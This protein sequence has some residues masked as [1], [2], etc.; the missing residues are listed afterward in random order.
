MSSLGEDVKNAYKPGVEEITRRSTARESAATEV[1]R[2]TSDVTQLRAPD[3]QRFALVSVGTAVLAPRVA[4]PGH[5]AMRVYGA[6]ADADDAREHAKI[7]EEVDPSASRILLEVGK[8]FLFPQDQ[9]VLDDPTVANRRLADKLRAHTQRRRREVAAFDRAVESAGETDGVASRQ[10]LT[11]PEGWSEEQEDD[12]RAAQEVYKPPKRL[13]AGAE[14]RN[15]GAVVLSI[16]PDRSGKGECAVCVVGC[17][18]SAREAHEWLQGVCRDRNVS[19][20]LVIANTCEWLYPNA[21]DGSTNEYWG[22]GELQ[23]IMD[24]SKLNQR[25]VQQYKDWER[26]QERLEA[27]AQ[28]PALLEEAAGVRQEEEEELP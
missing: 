19:T 2:P 25:G 11:G 1:A 21:K 5:P 20:D 7:V 24:A 14:V 28:E 27:A 26:E 9:E 4:D 22:V 12:E 3:G 6:F 17:F 18:E 15:Q 16:L 10:G 23:R 8:W 13:R